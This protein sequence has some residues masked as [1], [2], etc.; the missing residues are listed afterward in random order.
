MGGRPPQRLTHPSTDFGIKACVLDPVGN[1]A[2]FI[3]VETA[4]DKH[5]Q[6]AGH[7]FGGR[8]VRDRTRR[9]PLAVEG[10][11]VFG[12]GLHRPVFEADHAFAGQVGLARH[13]GGIKRHF[14]P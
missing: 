6:F 10:V 8:M 4:T 1:L 14:P 5:R 3:Q 12:R 13:A 2:P 7:A 11:L 9:K